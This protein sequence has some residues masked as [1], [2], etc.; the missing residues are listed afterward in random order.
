M[1]YKVVQISLNPSVSD[2]T[3]TQ[4]FFVQASFSFDNSSD[5]VPLLED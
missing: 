2:E 5:G 4:A 1:S 3:I